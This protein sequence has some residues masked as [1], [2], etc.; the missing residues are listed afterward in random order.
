MLKNAAIF[1]IIKPREK[2][3]NIIMKSKE[4]I[5]NEE[6]LRSVFNKNN[7]DINFSEKIIKDL[8]NYVCIFHNC[9]KEFKN[10]CRWKLHYI[11]HVNLNF[12]S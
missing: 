2:E 10:F 7:S 12:F 5:E 1:K 8:G 4:D 9:N 11:S 6:F 3:Q